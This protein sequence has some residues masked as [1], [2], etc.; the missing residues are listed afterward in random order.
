MH[1][2]KKSVFILFI[3]SFSLVACHDET[4]CTATPEH[5]SCIEDE[6]TATVDKP[7]N[8]VLEDQGT[9]S[10]FSVATFV[11]NVDYNNE[12]M[13]LQLLNLS[14]ADNSAKQTSREEREQPEANDLKI[15]AQVWQ[16]NA[17]RQWVI[18]SAP[19]S[20]PN[21]LYQYS[22]SYH[23]LENAQLLELVT[24]EK[25]QSLY[26][27]QEKDILE[28]QQAVTFVW[29]MGDMDLEG[30]GAIK[31][32]IDVANRYIKNYETHPDSDAIDI[33]DY[34]AT[35]AENA[36]FSE[37]ALI[38]GGTR[39]VLN[40]IMV[41]ESV[42]DNAGFSM[43]PVLFTTG[44]DTITDALAN[45]PVSD[46]ASA[47]LHYQFS[48][49]A[50]EH[51]SLYM[52]FDTANNTAQIFLNNSADSTILCQIDDGTAA[53]DCDRWQVS[54][55][56]NSDE[57]TIEIDI[58]A[59]SREHLSKLNAPGFFNI[60]IAGPFSDTKDF[61]YGKHYKATTVSHRKKLQPLFLL[62]PTATSD[63]QT[64]FQLWRQEAYEDAL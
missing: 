21:S 13:S 56:E 8:T 23:L 28:Q 50:T 41:I 3:T 18:N 45:Y 55:S 40:S 7:A 4:D 43:A 29:D 5:E 1:A 39:S 24:H 44:A 33:L 46:D 37:G 20:S 2:F 60:I 49:E 34:A 63:V 30:I 14:P 59:L 25:N 22:K 9:L 27:A 31:S 26:E 35:W 52:Q 16:E 61:Y 10:L 42:Y 53:Q 6:D 11:E 17:P 48:V 54:Y 12:S 15:D 36:R 62:N 32:R 58:M 57:A 51:H 19:F 47:S 64:Q 38:Y